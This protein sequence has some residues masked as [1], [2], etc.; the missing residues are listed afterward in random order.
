MV[1]WGMSFVWTTIVFEFL[2]PLSTVFI[3][4]VISSILLFSIL[5]LSGKLEYIQ[6]KHF[7]LILLSALFNPF[8]YFLGESYGVKYSTPTVSAVVIATIP[9]FSAIFATFLLRER[10]SLLNASGFLLSFAGILVMILRKDLSFSANPVGIACLLFAVLTAVS[11]SIILKKLAGLYPAFTIVTWQNILGALYFLPL[12]LIFEPDFIMHLKPDPKL[13]TP[14]L[15]LSVF[16]SSLAFVFFTIGTRE[17][18]V[19]RTNV[20]SNFIPVF[21]ALFSFWII[22]EEFNAAKLA[23]IA[24]VV[25]GVILSQWG[26][27]RKRKEISLQARKSDAASER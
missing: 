7:Q 15:L 16:A 10:L 11:Y 9:V 1:F 24:L 20:F 27:N 3:R 6:R 14:L 18:G 8:L 25:A 4:L 26:R 21:T 12:T 23:G 2:G 17:L 22:G 5:K 19:S 13:W